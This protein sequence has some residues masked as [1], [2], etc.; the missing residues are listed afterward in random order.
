MDSANKRAEIDTQPPFRSVR[1]AVSLFGERVLAGEVYAP[2]LKEVHAGTSS[3]GNGNSK[4]GSVT[5][6][7]E[8]TKQSLQK[9]REETTLMENSISSLKEEL[10]RTKRE[11][12]ELKQEK[13]EKQM[14][15]FEIEDLK[16]VEDPPK[17]RVKTQTSMEE[18]VE[19]QKRRYV[20]FA[21]PPLSQ[22]VLPQGTPIL[23]RHPSLKKK[24]KKTLMPLIGGIFS[25]KKSS[26]GVTLA[27]SP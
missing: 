3:H 26:F 23:E 11:L 19:F 24:K 4:F 13:C 14:T 16:F 6:E 9:A 17:S 8:E 27:R 2:K 1:E 22:V 20:T 21:N 12:Q 7:L 15:E 5:A 25:K 18:G 10:E